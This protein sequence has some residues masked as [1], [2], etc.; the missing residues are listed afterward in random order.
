[1]KV[2]GLLIVLVVIGASLMGKYLNTSNVLTAYCSQYKTEHR[3]LHTSY[4]MDLYRLYIDFYID[5]YYIYFYKDLYYIDF[6]IPLYTSYTSIYLY[7]YR[8]L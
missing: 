6:Y 1:M 8:L 5:L 3:L 2:V 4:Y 7:I